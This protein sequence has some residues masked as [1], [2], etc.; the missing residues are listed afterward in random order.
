MNAEKERDIIRLWNRLRA[1]QKEGRPTASILV[2]I[3]R[4]LAEAERQEA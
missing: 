3:N 1:L 2:R 4:A